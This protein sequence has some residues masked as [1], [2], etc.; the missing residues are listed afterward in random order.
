MRIILFKTWLTNIGNGFIDKGAK[1]CLEKAFPEAE[2]IE[3]SGFP[4][5][6]AAK[7]GLGLVGFMASTIRKRHG[8]FRRRF[9][10]FRM[11]R[12][13]DN[14]QMNNI[15]NIGELVNADLAVLPGCMLDYN[16]DIYMKTLK[17]VR[18]RGIP[19]IFLGAG[20][21]DYTSE[22]QTW[23]KGYFKKLSPTALFTRDSEA[24]KCYSDRFEASYDGIDCG[25]F[26]S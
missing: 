21:S 24:Y 20:G 17:K 25:F 22:T 4:N 18:E 10:E 1:V 14:P 8:K 11:K 12:I 6:I 3:V 5:L 15:I 13:E 7:R 26:I 2:I 9:L 23:V 16:L 19:L